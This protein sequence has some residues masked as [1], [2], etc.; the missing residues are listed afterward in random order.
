MLVVWIK[1][2]KNVLL[3][4]LRTLLFIPT[5]IIIYAI[6]NVEVVAPDGTLYKIG[7]TEHRN[8]VGYLGKRNKIH[9]YKR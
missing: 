2:M 1:Y 7:D 9:R 4:I 8:P 6:M 5:Y 3:A